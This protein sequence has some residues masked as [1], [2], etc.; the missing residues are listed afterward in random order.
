MGAGRLRMLTCDVIVLVSGTEFAPSFGG[1]D[2]CRAVRP[3]SAHDLAPLI[4]V[5][6]ARV[7]RSSHG[8]RSLRPGRPAGVDPRCLW[9]VRGAGPDRL[10]CSVARRFPSP[11]L[12]PDRLV[13][14]DHLLRMSPSSNCC[15]IR[16]GGKVR[17]DLLPA[18]S[19]GARNVLVTGLAVRQVTHQN[20]SAR[21]AGL[22]RSSSVAT[23]RWVGRRTWIVVMA[24][25]LSRSQAAGGFPGNALGAPCDRRATAPES[26]N[27]TTPQPR[28]TTATGPRVWCRTP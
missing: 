18:D 19:A 10:R 28:W 27:M 4:G 5:F 6:A 26:S 13:D 9:P 8:G 22:R 12:A 7:T 14:G 25:L 11:R 1:A 17:T 21:P 16:H 3:I 2:R 20:G 24:A 23:R 15:V